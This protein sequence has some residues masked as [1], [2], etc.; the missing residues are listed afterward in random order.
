MDAAHL[1]RRLNFSSMPKE[2]LLRLAVKQLDDAAAAPPLA[3]GPK[4]HAAAETLLALGL[5]VEAE[6]LLHMAADQD[7]KEAASPDTKAL[8]AIAALLA[9]RPEEVGGLMDPKLDGTDEIAL[10]RAVRL[11]MQ[12]EGSPEAAAVF[13]ATAP[14]VFQYPAADPRPHSAADGRDDDPGRG[15]RARG[16]SAGPAAG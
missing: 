4:H 7:P 3:R 14:L 15:D 16:A 8:T 12:D 10:W 9:G 5:S 2:A 6:S 11:A 1:T 13:A